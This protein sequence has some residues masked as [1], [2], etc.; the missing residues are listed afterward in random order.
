MKTAPIQEQAK[1]SAEP[2]TANRYPPISTYALIGDCHTAALI[3]HDGSID[4]YCPGR[5]DAPAVFCRM[6][7]AEKGGY[8]SIEPR[9]PSSTTRQYLDSTNILETTFRTGSG[10]VR[11]TDFMP[12]SRRQS[13]HKGYDVASAG[14]IIRLVDGLS[15]EVDLAVTF[16]PTFNFARDHTR[17]APVSGGVVAHAGGSFLTLS[18]PSVSLEV[19]Q[20]G[21]AKGALK[22]RAG[23]QHWVVLSDAGTE[24]KARAALHPHDCQHKLTNTEEYW[25]KWAARCTY[26][27]RYGENVLRSALT[28]KM[29]TYEPTGA[30]VAAPTT[31]LPEDIGG[32]RNWDYRY[33]WLRDASL[34]FYA[35]MTIGYQDEATDFI[36]WL[37]KTQQRAP[38]AVPQIMYGIDGS[39]KLNEVDLPNLEGYMGSKPVRIGNGAYDQFQLDIYGEVLTAAYVHFRTPT[40]HAEK[41]GNYKGKRPPKDTWHL[42][43][44]L[45]E[46]AVEKWREPDSGIWEVRGGPQQ[47]LYS[48]LMCWAAVDRG[49]KLAQQYDLQAPLDRWIET[50]DQIRKAILAEGYNE[51]IGAFTQAFG[52]PHLDASALII[53]RVGFLPPT[54]PRVQST[55]KQVQQHL[56]HNGFVYRYSTD[57]GLPGGEGTFT[58]CTL[59]MVDALALGGELE[60]AH[61]LFQKV[62]SHANDVGLL[63]EEINSNTGD[64]LGNFPQGFTHLAVIRSAVDLAKA[65][66][67]GPDKV[68]ENEAERAVQARR[69]ASGDHPNVKKSKTAV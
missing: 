61:E 68:A 17:L 1:L 52:S 20:H 43:R 13:S 30:I 54:D 14:Q 31:S 6:L 58:L 47:F 29:L 22:V 63:S 24:E 27:G 3:S 25:K 50:R 18:C 7:D 35:L 39:R 10:K 26:R 46:Q 19:D 9:D 28:L 44:T 55:I 38:T 41:H 60:E 56:T 12:V 64:L 4:W 37:R 69:A 23:E 8:M 51:K 62:L 16:K 2:T 5:F 34:I 67:H 40:N 15:G 42:L 45:A 49:I 48:K 59:W 33:S 66:K 57:D 11:V 32:V 53:P 21:A 36:H 65:A